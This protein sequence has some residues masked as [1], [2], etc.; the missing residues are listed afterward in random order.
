MSWSEHW[1]SLS[2]TPQPQVVEQADQADQVDQ[3][4]G[5]EVGWSVVGAVVGSVVG[6][7]GGLAQ[8]AGSRHAKCQKF[9][10]SRISIS[11]FYPKVRELRQFHNR[12]KTV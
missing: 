12:K 4:A 10:P 11:S 6:G 1:R 7:F 2:E 8:M 5:A 3:V 9:Y